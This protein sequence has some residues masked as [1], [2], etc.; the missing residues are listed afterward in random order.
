M[1]VPASQVSSTA[2][3]SAN[4]TSHLNQKTFVL[5][6]VQPALLGL[7]D[8][9]VSTLAPLFAA[10]GLTGRPLSAFFVGLAASLGAALSM[11]L[12]EA[13]SD[14]GT[15]TGRGGPVRRGSITGVATG[16]GGMLH[17]F[18]FLIP[19]LSVALNTAYVVVAC[20]LLAISFIRYRFMGGKLV[21]T[22]IQV[23]I[24]GAIVFAIGVVL[25]RVGAA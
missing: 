6:E 18:P 17:T 19:N 15:V 3:S 12:S 14:D 11:G 2:D 23:V 10:A 21:N 25:G 4:T 8:G 13:L 22:I 9:S 1:T 5:Q 24:G 16:L 20:E 7:M